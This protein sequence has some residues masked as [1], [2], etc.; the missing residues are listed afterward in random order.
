V[1]LEQRSEL[2]TWAGIDI[3]EHDLEYYPSHVS[4]LETQAW[5]PVVIKVI[6]HLYSCFNILYSF[7]LK[8]ECKE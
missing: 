7:W 2:S 5:R 4:Q 8:T 6:I 3:I 1:T